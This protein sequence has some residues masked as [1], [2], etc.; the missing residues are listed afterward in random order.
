VRQVVEE[1]GG[2]QSIAYG[3]DWFPGTLE[4]LQAILTEPG[5]SQAVDSSEGEPHPGQ[6]AA[7]EQAGHEQQQE[8][9]QGQRQHRWLA[10]T[11]S[12]YDRR[13]HLWSPTTMCGDVDGVQV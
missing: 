6:Q 4:Q 5:S 8:Q 1:Y 3:A 12:F 2:H 9:K 13:L 7:E 11:C 10:A